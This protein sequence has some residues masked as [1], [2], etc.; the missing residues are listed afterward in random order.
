MTEEEIRKHGK[1]APIIKELD[2]DFDKADRVIRSCKTT[3]QLGSAH[4]YTKLL[5]KKHDHK[6][7]AIQVLSSNSGGLSH[8]KYWVAS[9]LRLIQ[10]Y[11]LGFNNGRQMEIK[12]QEERNAR[13]INRI[14]RQ[15][16]QINN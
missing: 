16:V 1:L 8:G 13:Q 14:R 7:C 10:G 6:I 12:K 9:R 11:L 15:Q 2:A 4:N 3:R 5:F